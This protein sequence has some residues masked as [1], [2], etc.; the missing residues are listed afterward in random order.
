MAVLGARAKYEAFYFFFVFFFFSFDVRPFSQWVVI[1]VNKL[2]SFNMSEATVGI[3]HKIRMF[4]YNWD[5]YLIRFGLGTLE[6][7][8]DFFFFRHYLDVVKK[9]VKLSPLF[10]IRHVRGD[11]ALKRRFQ[12]LT[13]LGSDICGC[14]HIQKE[15]K[16]NKACWHFSIHRFG[17]V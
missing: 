6:E 2:Y 10:C 16:Q 3:S 17:L 13:F 1:F 7:T 4:Q 11:K 12:I 14:L 8:Y 9:I 15:T 5:L